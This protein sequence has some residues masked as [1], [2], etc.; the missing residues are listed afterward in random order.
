MNTNIMKDAAALIVSIT[1]LLLLIFN[2]AYGQT[3]DF[4]DPGTPCERDGLRP[5]GASFEGHRHP[6]VGPPP[7]A[8]SACNNKMAGT[9]SQF[10]T[11]RGETIKGTCRKV[12]GELVLI[13]DRHE[14]VKMVRRPCPPPRCKCDP[15]PSDHYECYNRAVQQ[16][17]FDPSQ[18]PVFLE[19]R[20]RVERPLVN[21]D[22]KESPLEAMDACKKQ[23]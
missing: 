1:V 19:Q 15:F 6:P 9:V 7:E 5:S 14:G 21:A 4:Q 18:M 8:Y 20:V 17:H 10:T 2:L 22:H 11:P 13:P 12:G 3:P 23:E 16:T